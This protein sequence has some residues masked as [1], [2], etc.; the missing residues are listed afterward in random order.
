MKEIND[1]LLNLFTGNDTLRPVMIFPNCKNGVV[2]ASD[3][4]AMI[5]IPENELSLRYKT[6]E[7]YPKADLLFTDIA[8]K[9]LESITVSVY[10]LAKE[11][12]KA[13]ITVDTNISKCNECGGSREVEWEY[14]SKDG[15]F[16]TK[17]D[18]C[19]VCKG[20]GEFKSIHPFAR[21]KIS[22]C[23][24][25][26]NPIFRIKVG[27][28]DYHPFQLYRLFL[29]ALLKGFETI[30]IFYNPRYGQTISY[31]G[32]IKVLVMCMDKE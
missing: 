12:V 20:D 28:L 2:Y 6:N 24:D 17:Q 26:D 7:K 5:S 11:L 18:E 30:E 15:D 21:I 25:E 13:R 27:N 23:G 8:A 3:A 19:P 29:V 9:S 10:E 31:F 22:R 4:H 32:D 1:F 14:E 16:H